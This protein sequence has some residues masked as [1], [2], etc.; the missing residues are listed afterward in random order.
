MGEGLL[1]V[2]DDGGGKCPP[3]S[4]PAPALSNG[5]LQVFQLQSHLLDFPFL[6][7]LCEVFCSN[8]TLPLKVHGNRHRGFIIWCP[9]AD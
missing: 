7:G 6:G 8:S 2:D 3:L 9:E 5:V 1:C 4:A